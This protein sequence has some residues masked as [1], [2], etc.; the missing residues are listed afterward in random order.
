M[1]RT[2]KMTLE[3]E[4]KA[5]PRRGS[6]R[7]SDARQCV[8]PLFFELATR[9]GT[10]NMPAS[11]PDLIAVGCTINRTQWFDSD[12]M[13]HDL[14][15]TPYTS[16]TPA[17]A[18]CYFSSAGPTATGASKPDLSAPGAMVVAAMSRDAEPGVSPFSAFAAP[19]GLCPGGSECL[20]VDADHA[21]LSGSSMSSPQV[22]G[23]VALLFERDPRLTQP[24]ILL[25][26]QGGARR[27]SGP[28]IADFQLGPGAL[29]VMGA[30]DVFDAQKSPVV[31]GPDPAASWLALAANYLHPGGPAL[32]GTVEVR[33]ADGAIADGF[34]Q[35]RLTLALGEEGAVDQPLAR[36]APGLYRFAVRA[37]PNTGTRFLR[38][39]VAIDGVAVGPPGSKVS[40]Q[41][42]I[43]IGADRWIAAGSARIYGGCNV[44]RAPAAGP[45]GSLFGI[46]LAS[47][48]ASRRYRRRNP[49][50]ARPPR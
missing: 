48:C 4:G 2:D 43:P 1:V 5:L 31:R 12:L 50:G 40:G 28:I 13:P 47:A 30:M 21:L 19:A 18:S 14:A 27:P 10:I 17:D 26:L 38:L 20:V 23:A 42:L 15:A 11:H 35:G 36:V 16:L 22:A 9:A 44:V 8:G 34:E 39:D 3:L 32:V 24:E 29:D 45:A 33:A 7:A 25:L 6:N 41:R 46:A 49:R 37:R